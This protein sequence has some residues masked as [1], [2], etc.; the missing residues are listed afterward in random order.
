[1]H[2]QAH[3]LDSIHPRLNADEI[4]RL[5]APELVVSRGKGAAVGLACCC[6]GF[7]DPVLDA[8][9]EL[10]P[11]LRSFPGDVWN[12]GGCTVSTPT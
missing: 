4:L 6:K 12:D 3:L 10:L 7:Q 9:D 2:G 11:L 5:T 8:Q 1:M